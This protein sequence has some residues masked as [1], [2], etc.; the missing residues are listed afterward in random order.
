M[1][2]GCTELCSTSHTSVAAAAAAA[3]AAEYLTA[4]RCP[5]GVVHMAAAS[6]CRPSSLHT[7]PT[8]RDLAG[9]PAG[10]AAAGAGADV[11]RL[12]RDLTCCG[13]CC[14]CCW[15]GTS[16][17]LSPRLGDPPSW[18]L[19]RLCCPAASA[20]GSWAAA[21][22]ASGRPMLRRSASSWSCKS[23][24]QIVVRHSV[25]MIYVWSAS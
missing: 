7:T 10:A 14:C 18:L 20:A 6:H 8:R 25:V 1:H 12:R 22:P 21:G 17:P 19:G 9:E 3:T 13:G 23:Q 4:T 15:P 11:L 5:S 2:T 24:G 16:Q